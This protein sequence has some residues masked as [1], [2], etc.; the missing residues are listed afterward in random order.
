MSIESYDYHAVLLGKGP[1]LFINL[2]CRSIL[3][4]CGRPAK[5]FNVQKIASLDKARGPYISLQLAISLLAIS[6]FF[7]FFFTDS[8]IPARKVLF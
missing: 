5:K 2:T 3:T 7:F 8:S 1:C 6:F 4:S